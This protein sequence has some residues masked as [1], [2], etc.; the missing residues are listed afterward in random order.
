[1][2]DTQGSEVKPQ[3]VTDADFQKEV[4]E[5]SQTMPVF[6]DVYADWC[7]PCKLIEPIVEKLAK[8]YA[9][10][11]KFVKLDSDANPELVSKYSIMSIPTLMVFVKGERTF[12]EAGAL[13]EVMMKDVVETFG[14]K[15]FNQ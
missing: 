10:K 14:V 11:V 6:L 5:A 12:G 7:P 3:F 13:N 8:E 15:R 2:D 1:M 9:G 4:I